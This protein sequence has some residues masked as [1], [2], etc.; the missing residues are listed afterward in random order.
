MHRF[1]VCSFPSRMEHPSYPSHCLS[2]HR[3]SIWLSRLVIL[4]V[5]RFSTSVGRRVLLQNFKPIKNE[6]CNCCNNK[7]FS[8]K[9][10]HFLHGLPLFDCKIRFFL[11]GLRIFAPEPSKLP[12]A[13][14]RFAKCLRCLYPGDTFI[15]AWLQGHLHAV[16][17]AYIQQCLVLNRMIRGEP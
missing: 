14:Y 15:S 1:R 11:I 6:H 16:P 3:I 5:V 4:G 12:P 2:Y 7:F 8:R 10:V 9:R 17:W 13:R